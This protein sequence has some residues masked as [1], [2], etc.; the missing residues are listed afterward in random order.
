MLAQRAQSKGIELAYLIDDDVPTE[1]RG[2][3]GRV[4]QVLANLVSNA[5]KFTERG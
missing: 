4:R 3:P 1:L 5:V 2:D